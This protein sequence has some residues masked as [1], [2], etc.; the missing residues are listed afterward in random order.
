MKKCH[1]KLQEL[2]EDVIMPDVEDSIDDIFEQIANKKNA[3]DESRAQLD[4]LH[5]IR[6]ELTEILQEIESDELDDEECAELYEEFTDM[7]S[8]DEE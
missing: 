2:I 3:T 7:I 4:E 5:E 8:D 6:D 1:K